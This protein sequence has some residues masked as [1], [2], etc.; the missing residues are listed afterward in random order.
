MFLII[1][2]GLRAQTG[3][4]R[5]SVADAMS[6]TPLAG[7]SV[8]I[9]GGTETI[10]DSAGNF[11]LTGIA[12]GR[13]TLQVSLPGYESALIPELEI[14]TGKDLIVKVPLT[15]RITEIGEV[16]LTSDVSKAN[17]RNK[18]AAV[19]ARQFT[20]E[21]VM[22]YAGGRMDVARLVTN[23]AGV[24]TA[25]DSRND[26][27][28]RG[29]SPTG[30]L[31]RMEGVP[32]PSPNHFSTL[33]TTG[34]PVSALNP[35]LLANSDFF[36][37]AFPAEYGN[38][39]SGVFDLSLRKGNKDRYEYMV[40]AGALPGAELMAEGP[41]G[42]KGGSFLA[43]VRYGI[44]GTFG[45]AGL[46]TAQP[47]YRDVAFNFDFGTYRWG[48]LSFYGIAGSSDIEFLG[49]DA[50]PDDIFAAEDENSR[51]RSRF[52][53]VGFKHTYDLS[54]YTYWRTTIGASTSGNVYEA[55]RFFYFRTP[56][57]VEKRDVQTD[58]TE[59]RFTIA[60]YIN[61]K[62]SKHLL[63]RSGILLE[64]YS[65]EAYFDT[66]N[67]QGDLDGDG[68]PDFNRIYDTNGSYQIIQPYG[69]VQYRINDR[70]TLNGGL[71][72]QYFSV[73]K[74]FVVEPRASLTYNFRTR[75][76][77][78]FGYGMHHQNV[79]APIMFQK[80]NIN[81]SLYANNENLD[82]IRS[83][84]FVMSYDVKLAEKWRGKAEAYYQ[85]IDRAAVE[86]APSSYSVL[87]EGADFIYSIDVP[88]LTSTG[89]GFNRGIE[90]TLEKFFSEGYQAL[91][92]SS[93]FESKYKGS[94][95]IERNTPFNNGFVL[96]V[97]GGKEWAVGKER[98]TIF[99]VNTKFSTSGGRY[100]T[101]VNLQASQQAGFEVKDE[102][103]AFSRQYASYFRWDVKLGMKI[104]S[105]KKRSSHQFYVD[106]QNVTN[107]DNIF[108]DRYNRLTN[109]I[110]SINQI[111]FFPDFGY[112]FQF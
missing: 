48:N 100:Y 84:H 45:S 14:V 65:L 67:Q 58:N 61:S 59:T 13:Q 80:E 49:R 21:E 8:S 95:G 10:T 35:N 85:Y 75:Q 16:V 103:N 69:Q 34:S 77:L 4:V 68:L 79:A 54:T 83:Q 96:N 111:G 91:I 31:W 37:S 25:D 24:S 41:M 26:I 98:R 32:I 36:T 97:L 107:R 20:M 108:V 109:Q 62:F 28:V 51:A 44:A 87:T 42:K 105:T 88:S 90:F 30:M 15:E 23:F 66:R 72:S 52:V 71:H 47:N 18:L 73:N 82:M 99:S 39:L 76:S 1:A 70:F 9:S 5:G 12:I 57:E 112:K 60:S 22:R 106:F 3:T 46:T 19:S 38:A 81:G 110:D 86:K 104:N 17:A 2:T 93:F 11:T 74:E 40:S 102:A 92:T 55:D 64:N 50:D 53:A 63:L 6:D 7:A 89:T 27:V 94:D 56:Q 33:G 101:P 43:A 29:N 78:S